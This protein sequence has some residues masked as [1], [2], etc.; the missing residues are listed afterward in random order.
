MPTSLVNPAEEISL[1]DPD[2]YSSSPST[3]PRPIA[4]ITTDRPVA[5]SPVIRFLLSAFLWLDVLASASTGSSF[6]LR[7]NH[8]RL[9]EHG[10]VEMPSIMGCRNWVVASVARACML[11]DWKATLEAERRLSTR[12]LVEEAARIEQEIHLQ[13]SQMLGNDQFEVT[14]RDE[15]PRA[16]YVEKLQTVIFA[17]GAL[18]YVHVIVSGAHPEVTEIHDGVLKML[19]TLQRL[20]EPHLLNQVTWPLCVAGCLATDGEHAAFLELASRASE[21]EQLLMS[22]PARASDGMRRCWELRAMGQVCKWTDT[23]PPPILLV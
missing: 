3:Q 8:I 15:E 1:I 16:D 4:T 11:N 7:F 22:G 5:D 17:L 2:P 19:R 21:G 9:L 6:T 20:P 14:C 18:I 12:K 10:P 13:A 23:G